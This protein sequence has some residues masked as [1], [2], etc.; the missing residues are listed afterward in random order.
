MVH[1]LAVPK[2]VG[3]AA[4]MGSS[5]PI[6]IWEKWGYRKMTIKFTLGTDVFSTMFLSKIRQIHNVHVL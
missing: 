4:V 2:P 1:K 3:E 5:N 6:L